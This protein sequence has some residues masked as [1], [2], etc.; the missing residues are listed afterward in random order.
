MGARKREILDVYLS[1]SDLKR[2][3]KGYVVYRMARGQNICLKPAIKDR[4]TVRQIDKLKKK[5]SELQ[6]SIGKKG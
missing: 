4:K 6:K 2:L 1:D 3:R 5:I